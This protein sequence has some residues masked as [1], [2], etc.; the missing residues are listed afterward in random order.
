[1]VFI[2]F[3]IGIFAGLICFYFQDSLSNNSYSNDNEECIFSFCYWCIKI[4]DT[5]TQNGKYFW[6]ILFLILQILLSMDFTW[7]IEYEDKKLQELN[8]SFNYFY[9]LYFKIGEKLVYFYEGGIFLILFGAILIISFMIKN[10]EDVKFK[11]GL[12]LFVLIERTSCAFF[13]TVQLIIYATY[14]IFYFQLKLNYQL[15]G[16]ITFGLFIII[17]FCNTILTALI[18]LPFK[19]IFK[20]IVKNCFEKKNINIEEEI[21]NNDENGNNLIMGDIMDNDNDNVLPSGL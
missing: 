4:F 19:V 13:N 21:K 10:E 15:L 18:V 7:I 8:D 20:L 3:F 12:N 14:C 16:M 9:Y 17:C 11:N 2:Y 5:L 1:M 6:I